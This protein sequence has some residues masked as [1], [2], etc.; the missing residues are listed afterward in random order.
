LFTAGYEWLRNVAEGYGTLEMSGGRQPAQTAFWGLPLYYLARKNM[1]EFT[2]V[3]WSSLSD[4]S[5]RP[6]TF[7]EF[8]GSNNLLR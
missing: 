6:L 4:V 8:N 7:N 3:I 5:F 1:V 2:D